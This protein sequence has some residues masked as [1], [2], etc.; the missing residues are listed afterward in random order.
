MDKLDEIP[1][2][3]LTHAYGSA[4]DVPELLRALKLEPRVKAPNSE[5]ALWHL[6]G[7]I[8]HQG[9]VYEATSYAVPF[10]LELAA[11]PDVPDRLGILE[12][13]ALIADGN[14]R[15]SEWRTNAHEAVAAG[16]DVLIQMADD[17]SDI[18]LAASHVLAQ[19]P[20]HVS[21]VGP[22]LEKYIETENRQRQCAGLI[23]LLGQV[24]DRS[25]KALSILSEAARST[26]DSVRLAAALSIG[27]L[28]LE[29]LPPHAREAIIEALT[30]EGPL[31]LDLPWGAEAECDILSIG[32]VKCL[33]EE[34]IHVAADIIITAVE[35]AG[36]TPFQV[37]NLVHLIF[38]MSK[39]G[40]T[41][42]LTAS[43]LSPIQ[44]RTVKAMLAAM[45]SG[46]RIFYCNFSQWGL[47]DTMREWRNLAAGRPPTPIDM[48]LPV[49]AEP[50]N[51]RKGLRPGLFAIGQQ[52]SHRH[53]GLGVITK[54]KS[55]GPRTMLDVNFDE[56]G[57]KTLSLANF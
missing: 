55:D 57:P 54:I 10:L 19:L 7:N 18:G 14:P 34:D 26:D 49:V 56:E 13:L 38:P 27:R 39:R 20:E 43:D 50:G 9:T 33:A 52:I 17:N 3:D 42:Q 12:L 31:V 5:S 47:P 35:S 6:C 36:A 4:E 23:L 2:K 28:R 48:S 8:W 15:G 29:P 32:L 11:N 53:F 16:L 25:V 37:H 40:L 1:W 41:P 22:L 24:Q 21:V 44:R 51:P 30:A 46:R 45:E